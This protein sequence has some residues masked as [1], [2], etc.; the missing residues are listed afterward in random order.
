MTKKLTDLK[1][2]VLTGVKSLDEITGGL[3][4]GALSVLASRPSEGKTSFGV[5]VMCKSS[6]ERGN[7]ILFVSCELWKEKILQRLYA[8]CKRI[9]LA[10]V[11]SMAQADK[12]TC[13]EHYFQEKDCY[14][15]DKSAPQVADIYATANEING[16]LCDKNKKLD[17]IVID[18]LQLLRAPSPNVGGREQEIDQILLQLKSLAEDLDVAVLVLCQ[19]ARKSKME[20]ILASGCEDALSDFSRIP[21]ESLKL[22]DFVGVLNRKLPLPVISRQVETEFFFSHNLRE[23]DNITLKFNTDYLLFEEK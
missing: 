22:I 5:S 18:Y 15:M 10:E 23:W 7:N 20:H 8:S 2:F 19:L 21:R 6:L 12:I 14:V 4:K 9:P 17:L 16:V 1:R 11:E 13:S 3:K